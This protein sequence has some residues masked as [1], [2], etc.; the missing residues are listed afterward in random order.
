MWSYAYLGPGGKSFSREEQINDRVQP[1]VEMGL[2]YCQQYE[3]SFRLKNTEI[4][5]PVAGDHQ[6][7]IPRAPNPGYLKGIENLLC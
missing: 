5:W 4:Q 1:L 2:I 7:H 6:L 3:P